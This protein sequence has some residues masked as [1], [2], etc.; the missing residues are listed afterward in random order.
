MYFC[1][2]WLSPLRKKLGPF[3]STN[4]NPLNPRMLCAKFG[5]NWPWFSR[6]RFQNFVNVFFLLRFYIPLEKG[7]ALYLNDLES[8]SPKDIFCLFSSG[9]GEDFLK[10]VYIFLHVLYPNYLPLGKGVTLYLNKIEY[11]TPKKVLCQVLFKYRLSAWSWRK[12]WKSCPMTI[13]LEIIWV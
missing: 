10:V 9:S 4:V 2:L 6:W 7:M 5:R 8:T 3:I 13:N 1:I 11:M 12:R